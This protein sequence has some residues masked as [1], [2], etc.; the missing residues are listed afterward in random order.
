M[1][2]TDDGPQS[3]YP[4]DVETLREMLTDYQAMMGAIERGIAAF[5]ERWGETPLN[6]ATITRQ[7]FVE[8]RIEALRTAIEALGG[9]L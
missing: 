1:A 9:A 8:R 3:C 5:R 2:T 6:A 4:E 7:A